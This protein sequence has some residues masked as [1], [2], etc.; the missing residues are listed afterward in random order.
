MNTLFVQNYSNIVGGNCKTPK[1]NY[2]GD[3]RANGTHAK[4]SKG[5][6]RC[7]GNG[8]LLPSCWSKANLLRIGRRGC[9]DGG[10][11]VWKLL[12]KPILGI[13]NFV[14]VV[15]FELTSSSSY[16]CSSNKL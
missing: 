9:R 7:I 11:E 5:T 3:G 15:C 16:P 14:D 1:R 13:C 12:L 10:F 6:T 8:Q 4:A 2:L